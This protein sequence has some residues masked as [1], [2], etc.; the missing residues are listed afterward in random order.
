MATRIDTSWPELVLPPGATITVELDDPAAIVTKLNVY[1]FT[2]ARQN[3]DEPASV[4]PLFS[5]GV[6]G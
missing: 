1:G 6:A 3:D 2:P 4:T 5:Y